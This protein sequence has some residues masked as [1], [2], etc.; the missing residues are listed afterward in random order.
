[1]L[2]NSYNQLLSNPSPKKKEH[3]IYYF[4]FLYCIKSVIFSAM[5]TPFIFILYAYH[6]MGV[7]RKY[8]PK[9]DDFSSHNNRNLLLDIKESEK[10]PNSFNSKNSL[11]NTS[12][13]IQNKKTYEV[14]SKLF[15]NP[16]KGKW[17]N[18]YYDGN[19]FQ[20]IY[21]NV[22]GK[23][24]RQ[25]RYKYNNDFASSN[26]LV[27]FEL[28]D[29]V[30]DDTYIKGNFTINLG[31]NFSNFLIENNKNNI[32]F[33]SSNIF[34]T[35]PYIK[36]KNYINSNNTKNISTTNQKII[37]II[38]KNF[39]FDY[40]NCEIISSCT[41]YSF[42]GATIETFFVPN[43][44]AFHTNFASNVEI[45]YSEIKFKIHKNDFFNLEF[46]LHAHDKNKDILDVKN[47]AFV[48]IVIEII[49]MWLTERQLNVLKNKV[50]ALLGTDTTTICIS[51]I[52]KALI[53]NCHFYRTI[54]SEREEISFLYG[55]ITVVYFIDLAFFD[56]RMMFTCAKGFLQSFNSNNNNENNG[57]NNFDKFYFFVNTFYILL[58]LCLMLCKML[59]MNYF[60]CYLL[61][62]SLW[63]FQIHHS[64][65]FGIRPPMSSFFIIFSTLNKLF[66]PIYLKGYSYNIFELKPAYAKLFGV[67][68]TV[69]VEVIVLLLQK[70]YGS[71]IFI[72]ICFKRFHYNYYYYDN[73]IV[74]EHINIYPECIICL[75][76]LE[77]DEDENL[78]N[79]NDVRDRLIKNEIKTTKKY[80]MDKSE[81]IIEEDNINTSNSN[82]IMRLINDLL[83]KINELIESI[84]GLI[85]SIRTLL[86]KK[87]FMITPCE[88]IFHRECLEKW[89]EQK[90]ECPYCRQKIPEID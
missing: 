49:Q 13:M 26:L 88:H 41:K 45:P 76:P 21:G 8:T 22:D 89:M 86:K 48:L 69:V 79:D 11:L 80:I 25:K 65:R 40:S 52:T 68:I 12:L 17:E 85:G 10:N 67:I 44:V 54:I 1:M 2:E 31:E 15:N 58:Y 90:T 53:C 28:K 74:Q 16:F 23:F 24:A 3:K 4:S 5:L 51:I 83:G 82:K 70:N 75:M 55:L 78:E 46:T 59:V 77:I 39:S 64:A 73:N 34:N 72:P 29:G 18:L 47:Y 84:K 32:H 7:K 87:K 62:F 81:N 6:I 66:L 20:N 42:N 60:S 36:S 37:H 61:F 71:T 30:Y 63:A 33:N 19:T 56:S 50:K 9:E 35:H 43:P 38:N 57:T 14:I 27:F